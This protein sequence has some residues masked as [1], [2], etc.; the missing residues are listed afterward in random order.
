MTFRLKIDI[1]TNKIW[2]K[3][4]MMD[5]KDKEAVVSSTGR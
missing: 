3:T 4:N 1:L 5:I 2:R